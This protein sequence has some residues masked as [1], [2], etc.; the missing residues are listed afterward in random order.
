M[1]PGFVPVGRYG[2]AAKAVSFNGST[3]V[4]RGNGLNVE[5]GK[6]GILSYWLKM[7]KSDAEHCFI[8]G[9]S[10]RMGVARREDNKVGTSWYESVGTNGIGYLTST[11]ITRSSGWVH[12]IAAWRTSTATLHLYVNGTEDLV[13]TKLLNVTLAYNAQDFAIGSFGASQTNRFLGD[14]A[15]IYFTNEYLDI[16]NPANL[17]K[18]RTPSGRPRFLGPNGALPTGNQPALYLTGPAST[19]HINKGYGG[20]FTVNGTLTDASSSP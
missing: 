20:N 19:F 1:M 2:Y 11:S 18:F 8:M 17:G 5:D 15:E 7:T 3:N 13:L 6:S 10:T 14:I 12:I 4:I 16:S 9:A